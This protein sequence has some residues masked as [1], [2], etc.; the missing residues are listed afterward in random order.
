MKHVSSVCLLET[1]LYW[2]S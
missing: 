1:F 2:W